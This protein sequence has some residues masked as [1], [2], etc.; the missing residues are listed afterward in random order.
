MMSVYSYKTDVLIV[1]GGVGGC[2]A[3]LAVAE[4][5]FNVVMTEPTDW[6]GGQLTSQA[7]PPDEHGWIE[8]FGCT[9]GYRRFREGVRAYYRAHYPLTDA[10][11]LNPLLNPGNGW[12]SPLCHEPRVA[13]AVL[14]GLLA[15]HR[16]AGRVRILLQLEP[17]GVEHLGDDV[18]KAVHFSN[19]ETGEECS[20]EAPF[21]LDATELGELLPLSGTE[22]VTGFE[23]Q[24]QTGEP[25]APAKAQPENIQAFSMCFALDHLEGED[26][27]IEQPAKYAFWRS[28]IPD[29]DPPWP[30]RFLSWTGVSPRTM[31][32]SHYKFNPNREASKMFS[33][34]WTFRRVLDRANFEKGRFPSDITIVN[35]PMNDHLHGDLLSVNRERQKRLVDEAREQSLAL[36]YWMQTEAPRPD[37]GDGW[38]GL[39]LR[40]D[41]V[42]TKDGL[43]KYPYIR[44]S[45]RIQAIFTV[46]EQHVAAASRPGRTLA[47]PFE[48]SVGIGSYRIDLHPSTGG[49]N[50][51]DVASCPFQ[52]PLG[53]LIPL[54][55]E[56]L[57]PACKNL[58]T[59]HI[60]NGCYRLH[61][62]E[63]N[64]GEA[65]G[66]LSTFCL[67]RKMKP[68]QV[69]ENPSV[70]EDFQSFL[71]A[72]GVERAWPDNLNVEEGDAHA[73][74]R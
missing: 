29:L 50:Y 39:R 49:D 43:A 67:Q 27:T 37:G 1:G 4:S 9:R 33:G 19:L 44:E 34:L 5:G 30:G 54:R 42:G 28:F 46:R 70:R 8:R 73:H 26:H 40:H 57:L 15:P 55:V 52:I 47:E 7:V 17:I 18:L 2:A 53:A 74:A 41:V 68:R 13:L 12:V 3:A 71:D 60:T 59:T 58:G 51:I 31:Q 11:R 36:L 69:Y 56:N 14:Q 72:R 38:P 35:W 6:I 65:A 25:S 24:A 20:V 63:W 10:A 21:I 22:Y 45:R 16:S 23:S 61:P 66:A 32:P 64:I 48:D 62:V